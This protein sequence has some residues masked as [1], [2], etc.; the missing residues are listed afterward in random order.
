MRSRRPLPSHAKLAR[1]GVVVVDVECD[2]L[3]APQATRV[4]KRQERGVAGPGGLVMAGQSTGAAGK[5]ADFLAGIN[6]RPVKPP[7]RSPYGKWN[8]RAF[9][10]P[11]M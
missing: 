8:K 4:E 2:G 9:P 3:G 1:F 6:P 5:T 11:I 7:P 10:R